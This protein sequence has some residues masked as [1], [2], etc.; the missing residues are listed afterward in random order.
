MAAW[1]DSGKDIEERSIMM[2]REIRGLMDWALGIKDDELSSF[3]PFRLLSP[4]IWL[5]PNPNTSVVRPFFDSIS[6]RIFDPTL[7]PIA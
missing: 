3:G 5:S 7:R 2:L 4:V 1:T 6:T